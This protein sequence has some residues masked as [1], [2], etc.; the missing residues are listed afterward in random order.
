MSE[1]NNSLTA[2]LN[3]CLTACLICCLLPLAGCSFGPVDQAVKPSPKP[4][5][6]PAGTIAKLAMDG[7]HIERAAKAK[8]FDEL[9]IKAKSFKSTKESRDAWEAGL[10][11]GRRAG[12]SA[13]EKA[14]LSKGSPGG[15]YDAD[16][17][18]EAYS[19]MAD[20]VRKAGK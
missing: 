17:T 12:Y 4:A 18:S 5:P 6:V 14:V 7:E 3:A 13:V 15:K 11:A 19:E 16:A 2:R 10:H 20:G 8:M 1:D 9:A